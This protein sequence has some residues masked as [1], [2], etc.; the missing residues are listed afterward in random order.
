MTSETRSL[1]EVLPSFVMVMKAWP[2]QQQGQA[3][4]T[5]YHT[6]ASV[7][8]T[9]GPPSQPFPSSGPAQGTPSSHG[10]FHHGCQGPSTSLSCIPSAR[11]QEYAMEKR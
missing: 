3:G 8:R 4:E 9:R 7:K 6:K 10:I 1:Q 11:T 2:S 5:S